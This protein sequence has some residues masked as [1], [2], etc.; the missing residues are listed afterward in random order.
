[1]ILLILLERHCQLQ[2][3]DVTIDNAIHVCLF[4]GLLFEWQLAF[5]DNIQQFPRGGEGY[6]EESYR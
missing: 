6:E 3:S 5:K 1:M 4:T 2:F